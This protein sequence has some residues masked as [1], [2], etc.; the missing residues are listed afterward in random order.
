MYLCV[1]DLIHV[2]PVKIVIFGVKQ[3][4]DY[5]FSLRRKPLNIEKVGFLGLQDY[6]K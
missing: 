1:Y 2:S 6:Y 5:S 4:T 3:V